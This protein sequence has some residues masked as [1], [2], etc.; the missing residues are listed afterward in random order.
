MGDRL[1]R[2]FFMALLV[3]MWWLVSFSFGNG[4]LRRACDD[5]TRLLGLES[6]GKSSNYSWWMFFSWPEGKIKWRK[7][8]AHSH[9]CCKSFQLDV[10]YTVT[11]A[12]RC[13]GYD[14]RLCHRLHW[15]MKAQAATHF[16]LI[17]PSIFGS[18]QESKQLVTALRFRQVLQI[19][20]DALNVNAAFPLIRSKWM[21]YTN[22]TKLAWHH[23]FVT[24]FP[25]DA[26]GLPM[27]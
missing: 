15:K 14:D 27:P 12:P 4:S 25:W 18:Q 13:A 26:I 20:V 10:W 6:R 1:V 5:R 17:V 2:L 9:L 23:G 22:Y 24:C 11:A 8:G 3:K 16:L 21:N 19:S 7:N